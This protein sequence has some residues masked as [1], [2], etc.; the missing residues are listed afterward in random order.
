[1]ENL[2]EEINKLIE[3][4]KDDI[5]I[6]I[7]DLNNNKIIYSKNEDEKI[8]AASTIKVQIML[9]ILE[10]V[11]QDKI[12]IDDKILVKSTDILE[13]TEVFEQ[14]EGYYTIEE[15]LNWMIIKSDNTAT[16]VLINNF[17][18]NYINEY[19]KQELK[20]KKTEVN[21]LMLDV[22]ARKNRKKNYMYQNDMLKTYEMLYNHKILNNDLC[23]LAID[24]LKKQ[25]CQNQ[26]VRYIYDEVDFAH[27]TGALDY[28]NH[29]VGVMN[30]NNQ[31]IYI[32]ASV[33][34]CKKREGNKQIIG[35]IGKL[36]YTK[37][38]NSID[39]FLNCNK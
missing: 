15:L 7:K 1:M 29:D 22:K 5:A 14:G 11:K 30:I 6:L 35:K 18:F 37:V 39:E 19:I 10:Q 23:N 21:R 34:N 24:I 4:E 9:A 3:N 12:K 16:N 38:K 27:K 13:D 20:L 2:K 31:I 8:V 36:V 17:G 33:Y 26:I 25:R 32:G 28:L